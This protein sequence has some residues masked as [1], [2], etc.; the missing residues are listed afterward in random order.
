MEMARAVV[1]LLLAVAA[2]SCTSAA[3]SGPS[4]HADDSA[5]LLAVKAAFNNAS[6]FEYWTPEFPCCDWYG[7]DCGDD[8]LPSDDR[9]ISLAITRD[10]N[11][12]GT[13]P[14]DAIAGL[15]RLRDITFF[16]VPGITGPIPAALA[17][18]SGLR[19]L[20]ISHTAVSGPIPSFIGDKF[21]DLG[22]LDLSFNSLT[23][24][25]P[26]SLAKPPKLNSIDLSRNRLTGSIPRLL[27]SKAGQQAFL[28]LSHN[29]LTGRIPAEFGAVN[30]VQ[31]DLSRNQ[32]T[33]DAS[34]LFGSGKKELVSAYLSRNAL[35]FNMSQLQLPEEL[36]FLDVSHNSIYGSIPAQM[37]NMTDIQLLNVSYNRLCGEVPT[38]GNMPSFDAYCFQ[39][40]KCLCGA[41]LSPCT[42]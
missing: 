5:A 24:A 8:Y 16:K 33:G 13:I 15:T 25:I 27:L 28:T 20:T 6:F 26:A 39:H 12:T 31:I 11:I 9:V 7:V 40:N 19:V 1:L 32:L 41:P 3:A 10:D 23:G 17:N 35:S 2:L 21:T 22:I 29:N 36:N 30:F 18:I 4:C 14:G 34:M 42:H 38:G 37:A